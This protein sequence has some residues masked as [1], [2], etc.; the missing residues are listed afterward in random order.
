[1]KRQNPCQ[2]KR[3]KQWQLKCQDSGYRSGNR[4]RTRQNKN[5]VQGVKCN[6]NQKVRMPNKMSWRESRQF[7]RETTAMTCCHPK[8][9]GRKLNEIDVRNVQVAP[10]S[11]CFGVSSSNLMFKTKITVYKMH[12]FHQKIIAAKHVMFGQGSMT[13]KRL[14]KARS[15]RAPAVLKQP[16]LHLLCASSWNVRSSWPPYV[17]H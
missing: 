3:N 14:W 1:M 17:L 9:K 8:Q 2:T 16:D 4:Q 10:N 7:S 13:L 12:G 11:W 6:I 15:W 5:I